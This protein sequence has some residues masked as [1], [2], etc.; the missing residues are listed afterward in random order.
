MQDI[1]E[2]YLMTLFRDEHFDATA[3][4]FAVFSTILDA[5]KNRCGYTVIVDGYANS[6]P[7]GLPYA[8]ALTSVRQVIAQPIMK[9]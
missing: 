5:P 4:R 1:Y 3:K 2:A 8:Q 6:L 7:S 9:S